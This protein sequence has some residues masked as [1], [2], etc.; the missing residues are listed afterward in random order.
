MILVTGGTGL[1]GSH[2]LYKLAVKG[3]KIRAIYRGIEKLKIVQKIFS[4]YTKDY[5]SLYTS[6]EWIKADL[7]DLPSLESAFLNIEYVYH[8]AGFIS[9]KNNDHNA[10]RKVNIEGTANIVNLAIKN[11]IKKLCHVSSI[12]TLGKNEATKLIDEKTYW[13]PEEKN[14]NYAISKYG[15]EIE[16]WRASQEGIK[17]IIVNPGII[18]GAGFD[19]GSSKIF[20]SVKKGLNFYTSGVNGFVDVEDLVSIMIAL[21]GSNIYNENYIVISDNWSF[22]KLLDTIAIALKKP[23]PKKKATPLLLKMMCVIDLF[24]TTI[25]GKERSFTKASVEAFSNKN[26]YSNKKVKDTLSYNFRSLEKTIESIIC[27][28]NTL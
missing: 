7:N 15:A 22:K 20:S 27:E 18:L 25:T 26:Y 21:M 13:N 4:L 6:I 24:K 5:E 28:R 16:V 2:L 17:V 1:V 10:L 19:S 9:F 8:C 12:A 14:N 23:V 3:G 11:N